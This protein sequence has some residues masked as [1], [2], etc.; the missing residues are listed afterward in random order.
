MQDFAKLRTNMVD[1]QLRTNGV[2]SYRLLDA[3]A[4]V[5][6]EMF[7]DSAARPVAYADCDIVV[8]ERAGGK[9]YLP[10]PMVFGLFG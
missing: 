10:K 5:P 2:T 3:M 9:R 8:A 6:R 7:V 4:S 1:T